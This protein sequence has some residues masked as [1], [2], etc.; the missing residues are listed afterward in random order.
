M[1]RSE[2]RIDDAPFTLSRYGEGTLRLTWGSGQRIDEPAALRAMQAVDDANGTER[3]TLIVDAAGPIW[4]TRKAR[5]VFLTPCTVSAVALVARNTAERVLAS[6][7]VG[8]ATPPVPTRWFTSENS[9]RAWL[10]PSAQR[11]F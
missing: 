11:N 7:V 8:L 5:L 1:S 2:S 3:G 9:A 10:H 4:M 6:F